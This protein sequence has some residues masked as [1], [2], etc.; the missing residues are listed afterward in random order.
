MFVSMLVTLCTWKYWW[1][2]QVLWLAFG[3]FTT[4]ADK[5]IDQFFFTSKSKLLFLWYI[6]CVCVLWVCCCSVWGSQTVT[7]DY[8]TLLPQTLTIYSPIYCRANL[9]M[10]AAT[11]WVIVVK[12][13]LEVKCTKWFKFASK[14]YIWKPAH[15]GECLTSNMQ[16]WLCGASI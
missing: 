1:R 7:V 4:G 15:C 6:V 11:L 14:I 5:S 10:D 9:L 8:E 16:S 2:W 12:D 13:V 3:F